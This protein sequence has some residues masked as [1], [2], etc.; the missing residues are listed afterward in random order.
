[1][2]IS[3]EG[4]AWAP[5]NLLAA[6]EFALGLEPVFFR[7]ASGTAASFPVGICQT[8][9]SFAINGHWFGESCCGGRRR[10]P[11]VGGAR[12]LGSCGGP[13]RGRLRLG[14]AFGHK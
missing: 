1:M 10:F 11:G 3:Y 7:R 8:C 13:S 4:D 14:V 9:D 12:A 5:Y 6:E 2:S